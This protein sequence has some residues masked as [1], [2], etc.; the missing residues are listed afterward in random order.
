MDDGQPP[1]V[2]T[3]EPGYSQP[4]SASSALSLVQG[5]AAS[6]G[7]ASTLLLQ[8]EGPECWSP[9]RSSGFPPGSNHRT[10]PLSCHV[11]AAKGWC[12]WESIWPLGSGKLYL[13]ASAALGPRAKEVVLEVPGYVCFPFLE[14]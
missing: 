14:R 8:A 12:L 4:V 11:E 1:S 6:F 9:A 7:A 13:L 3:P 5:R 2:L 10:W